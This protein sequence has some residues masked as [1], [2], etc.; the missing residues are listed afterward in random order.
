[1]IAPKVRWIL[2]SFVFLSIGS[3]GA[4]FEIYFGKFIDSRLPT[5][6]KVKSFKRTG[7]ITIVST[8]KKIIQKIGPS[9]RDKVNK[10]L[11]PEEIKNAFIA[12]EDRRYYKHNGVDLWGIYRAMITNIKERAIIE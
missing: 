1:M 2:I 5:A 11:I 3:F 7:T 10:N 12:S 4:L 6:E 8:N 9:T